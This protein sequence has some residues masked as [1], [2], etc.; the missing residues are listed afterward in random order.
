MIRSWI[1]AAAYITS[2]IGAGYLIGNVGVSRPVAVAVAV[3]PGLAIATMFYVTMMMIVDTK[4][5]F[6]RMLAV[7]QQLIAAGFA[8]S[9][10]S[11]W[12][13]LEVFHLVQHMPTFYVV[14]LWAIGVFVGLVVNR[15]THGVWGECP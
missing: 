1:V 10:A 9:I 12:G 13:C 15:I 2:M 14:I 11:V 8:F 6:M 3:V 7:R 4:D 5:E